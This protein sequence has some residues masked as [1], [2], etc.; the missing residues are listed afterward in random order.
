LST[1][2]QSGADALVRARPP[3]RAFHLSLIFLFSALRLLFSALRLAA[4]DPFEIHIY[5]YEPTRL[6]EYSLE[7]HLNMNAQGTAERDGALLPTERQVHLTLEPTAGLSGNFALGFMFLNAWQPG[8][9]PQFAGWR[10][11]PHMYAPGS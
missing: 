7:A 4:Q 3:G 8:Y 6:G 9:S 1:A 5:E 10:A 2:R 11:L